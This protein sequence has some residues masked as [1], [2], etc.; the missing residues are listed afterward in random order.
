MYGLAMSQLVGMASGEYR[1]HLVT[2]WPL[3]KPEPVVV[4]PAPIA[5][6]LSL[7]Q[8]T[9]KKGNYGSW[10]A[11]GNE[12]SKHLASAHGLGTTW[13][14]GCCWSDLTLASPNCRLRLSG[15]EGHRVTATIWVTR[16]AS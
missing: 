1:H 9:L 5:M 16:V 15:M 4:P 14:P 6:P 12:N 11:Y 2:T 10:V 13:P 7:C 3:T 8:K